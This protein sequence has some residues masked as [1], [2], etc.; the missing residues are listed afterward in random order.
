MEVTD[1]SFEFTGGS[2]NPWQTGVYSPKVTVVE[3]S[4][5]KPNEYTDDNDPVNLNQEPITEKVIADL[6]DEN[7]GDDD[8]E[9]PSEN[10]HAV[11]TAKKL[12]EEGWLNV[13]ELPEDIDYPQIYELFKDSARERLLQEVQTEVEQQLASAGINEQN[14]SILSALEN[15][16]PLDEVSQ[17]S[18]F[19]KYIT[20]KSDD[21]PEDKKMAVIRERYMSIGLKEK[22][23]E[24]QLTAIEQSG[25]I[26]EAFEESQQFFK[27]VVS[28]FDK[29]QILMAQQ[30]RERD[31]EIKR[32][33][34]EILDK[35]VRQGELG[36]QKLTAEE[37]KDLHKSIIDRSVVREV[38]GTKYSFS[39]FEEFL[40]LMN[41]DFEFQLLQFKNYKFKN[42]ADVMDKVKR[43][44]V[45]NKDDWD[46]VRK[47][48]E[49]DKQKRSLKRG[50][51]VD[52]VEPSQRG[53]TIEI[54]RYQ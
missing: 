36:N 46:A 38:D 17:V 43:A 49:A 41:N 5:D 8:E 25:E 16:V 35:A 53:F 48:Q 18:R 47:A 22:D 10:I 12:K 15:G 44:E 39:P 4:D 30:L 24:R 20:L 50:N 23:L 9:V 28:E 19:K 3:T 21:Q 51:T 29:S 6:S 40:Y 33:N 11:I 32:K 27:G 45:A 31:L 7:D 54:P 1:N 52:K 26:D 37:Q 13:E 2:I 42:K 34:Q 14:L